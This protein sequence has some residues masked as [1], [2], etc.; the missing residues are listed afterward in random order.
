M[1][2]IDKYE[3]IIKKCNRV[4][5]EDPKNVSALEAKCTALSKLGRYQEAIKFLDKCLE[6]DSRNVELWVDKGT[7]LKNLRRYQEAIQCYDK[8]Q[9]ILKEHYGNG[10][11][12]E[13]ALWG[14]WKINKILK[15]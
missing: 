10:A 14:L 3:K 6:F 1:N 12:H 8:A 4:L 15:K 2:D 5:E 9:Q 11:C 7:V 13:V